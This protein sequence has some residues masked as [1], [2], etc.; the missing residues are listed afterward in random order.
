MLK[1]QAVKRLG[2]KARRGFR[3][4]PVAT[5]AFYGPDNRMATKAAVAIVLAAEQEPADL[6]R[7]LSHDRDV[8]TDP[9]IA[10][11]ILTFI[12]G[13]GVK[14]VTMADRI[15]GCPHEEGI[16]Y[17]GPTCPRCPYWGPV[18]GRD[19]PLNPSRD[20]VRCAARSPKTVLSSSSR[21]FD[22]R[23]PPSADRTAIPTAFRW[24][25]STTSFLPLVTPV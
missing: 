11:E 6:R 1:G 3:G 13:A 5:I 10:T 12:D 2:K 21:S 18:D 14:T 9:E 20:H 19:P 22:H 15:I 7:W 23:R 24:P 16:D 8:R 17:E 4:Y 25:T